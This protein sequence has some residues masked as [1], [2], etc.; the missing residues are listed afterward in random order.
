MSAGDPSFWETL[1]VSGSLG[2]AVT[3]PD[4]ATLVRIG[5]EAGT[6][7]MR[8]H[9]FTRPVGRR[10]RSR[11]VHDPDA[12]ADTTTVTP[13]DERADHT[14]GNAQVQAEPPGRSRSSSRT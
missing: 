5:V 13:E 10:Q 3:Y 1:V 9:G 6:S 2:L 8:D 11:S 4:T 14:T 7:A 12:E